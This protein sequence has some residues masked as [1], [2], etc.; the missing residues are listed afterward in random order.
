VLVNTCTVRQKA[1]EKARSFF[2]TLKAAKGSGGRPFIVG[3]GCVVPAGRED[4]ARRYPQ[5]DL[6]IDYS[7]PDIVFSELARAFAPLSGAALHEGYTPLG[8]QWRSQLRFIT[9]IRGCNHGCSYCV[10]P[11]ARGPQRDVPLGR[12]VAEAQAYE[13]AGVP[14]IA[15]L[16]Q[17]VLAYG[18][19][20][21]AD[22]PRFVAL[23]EALLA[24]TGFRWITFLTS[25]ASDLSD[26][27]CE[28][29]IAHPRISPLLHLPLQSGSDK[30]LGD[31]RRGHDAELYRR[32]VAKARACRPDLYL[33]TDLLVGFPTEEDED[34]AATLHLAAE[35]GFDDAFMFAYSP[36]PNTPAVRDYL[37]RWTRQQKSA[38]LTQ[39]IARQRELSA[40][41]NQRF[42]GQELEVIIEQRKADGSA[43]ARTAFNKPVQLPSKATRLGGFTRVLITAAKVSSFAGREVPAQ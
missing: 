11:F 32:V 20:G 25:L 10:V 26:E 27:I 5:I 39:L 12:I 41:R 3:M 9:A 34:Y 33:T 1:E 19:S 21:A 7:D 28:R 2:G 35:V 8:D 43:V 30:V 18:R 36:R 37:E 4:L 40:A 42:V 22:A 29:I 6:L 17:N 15:V 13:K 24:E 23:M 16:G 14:D 38:R 31:M